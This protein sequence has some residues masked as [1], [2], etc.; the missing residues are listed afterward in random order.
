MKN[1]PTFPA[2]FANNQPTPGEAH[3]TVSEMSALKGASFD[4]TSA[5]PDTLG[6][7]KKL[8]DPGKFGKARF[9]FKLYKR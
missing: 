7:L 5:L 2:L 6:E 1:K 8:Q 3:A 4:M 9:S